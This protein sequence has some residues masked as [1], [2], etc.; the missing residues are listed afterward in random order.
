MEISWSAEKNEI[1]KR[2]RG[3]DFEALT[4]SIQSGDVLEVALNPNHPG[5]QE[6]QTE[7]AF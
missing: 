7:Q 1:L 4:E 2:E 3:L 6:P 5:V